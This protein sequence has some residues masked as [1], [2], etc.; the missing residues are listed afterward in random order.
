MQRDLR[1]RA[2]LQAG[3]LLAALVVWAVIYAVWVHL[4]KGVYVEGEIWKRVVFAVQ[5][6]AYVAFPVLLL[7]PLAVVPLDRRVRLGGILVGVALIALH[8]ALSK[9]SLGYHLTRDLALLTFAL[10]IGGIVGWGVDENRHIVPAFVVLFIVDVWSVFHG[11]SLSVSQ[12]P[13][14]MEHVLIGSPVVGYPHRGLP[15]IGP[16]L[17]PADIVIMVAAIALAVK[18]RLGLARTLVSVAGGVAVCFFFVAFLGIPLPLLPFLVLALIIGHHANLR[19]DLR[20][21]LAAGGFSLALVGVLTL[22]Q[23]LRQGE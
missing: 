22:I 6:T 13:E 4:L 12:K 20:S 17:G 1:E 5:S 18:F 21:I 19:W 3:Y 16:L 11:I 23:Y 7:L 2:S 15:L 8:F 14:V 9:G 10:V